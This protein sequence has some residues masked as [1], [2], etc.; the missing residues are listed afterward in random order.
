MVI[1]SS[2]L[3]VW[4]GN[5]NWQR[6]SL[7]AA[8]NSWSLSFFIVQLDQVNILKSSNKMLIS[9]NQATPKLRQRCIDRVAMSMAEDR[10]CNDNSSWRPCAGNA[11]RRRIVWLQ[12]WWTHLQEPQAEG[13]SVSRLGLEVRKL[14]RNW[15]DWRWLFLMT[16]LWVFLQLRV[17]HPKDPTKTSGIE[18]VQ[19]SDI[20]NWSP[21]RSRIYL[22]LLISA[23]LDGST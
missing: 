18:M 5:P 1:Y 20:W 9:W 22:H 14:Q 16:I 7:Q 21:Y 11:G 23:Q 13:V 2:I 19:S 3:K 4:N 10:C 8:T 6:L 12:W 15:A 17:W